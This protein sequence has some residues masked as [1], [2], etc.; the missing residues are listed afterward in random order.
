MNYLVECFID[1]DSNTASDNQL[2]DSVAEAKKVARKWMNAHDPES[3][4]VV[5]STVMQQELLFDS[6]VNDLDRFQN[7]EPPSPSRYMVLTV[8]PNHIGGIQRHRFVSRHEAVK[9]AKAFAKRNPKQ[10][11]T[12]F[13]MES[14]TPVF[15]GSGECY[16]DD[17]SKLPFWCNQQRT[18]FKK[19]C[20][21]DCHWWKNHLWQV[22]K[23][24]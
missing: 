2:V 8:H 13:D 11:G 5:I 4:K 12:V 17:S 9:L 18:S 24:L 10:Y 14:K 1:R 19:A 6:T 15:V 23:L 22:S 3:I 16:W 7:K 21:D 20:N